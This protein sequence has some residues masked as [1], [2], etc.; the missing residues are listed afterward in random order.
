MLFDG[1]AGDR[2]DE[3]RYKPILFDQTEHALLVLDGRA[4]DFSLCTVN[5]HDYFLYPSLVT[6]GLPSA[7]ISGVRPPP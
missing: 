4:A 1:E 7:S 6:M 5:R 3:K 2:I